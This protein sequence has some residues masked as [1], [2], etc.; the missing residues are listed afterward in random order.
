MILLNLLTSFRVFCRFLGI[1]L[2]SSLYH[3]QKKGLCFFIS[4]LYA[5][6]F[7]S[8]LIVLIRVSRTML[9]H[10]GESGYHCLQKKKHLRAKLF[11]LS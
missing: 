11:S 5:F 8:C 9:S 10:S 4:N 3:L 6:Y 1:F 7:F 2:C